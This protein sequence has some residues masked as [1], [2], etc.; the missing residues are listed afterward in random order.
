MHR[1]PIVA[2]AELSTGGIPCAFKD[3]VTLE[4]KAAVGCC[5]CIYWLYKQDI[6]HTTTYPHLLTLAES[7]GCEY[8]KALNVHVGHNATYTSDSDCF[9]VPRKLVKEMVLQDMKISDFY[10]L[11]I[12]ESTD[13]SVL[14]QLMLYGH[15]VVN[16][17][18]PYQA[19]QS[20]AW[21]FHTLTFLPISHSYL[22]YIVEYSYNQS[23][24]SLFTLKRHKYYTCTCNNIRI[25]QAPLESPPFFASKNIFKVLHHYRKQLF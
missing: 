17:Q 25:L 8:F 22:V 21:S 13:V 4:M 20:I 19:F 5:K 7:F 12:D 11:V 18:Q 14:K 23:Y 24:Y 2:E 10:S 16:S 1:G 15:L 6:S 3:T 9:R